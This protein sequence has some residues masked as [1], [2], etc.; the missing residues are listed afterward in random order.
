MTAGDIPSGLRLCRASGWN[1]LSRDWEHFLEVNPDGARVLE[2]QER[3][4]G[5]VATLRYGRLGWLAMVLVDPSQRRQGL[6]TQLLSAGLNLLVDVE[7]V[8][9]DATPAGEGMYRTR[10]F[11]E[12]ERLSRM[13][14]A[15][16]GDGLSPRS[17]I[18]RRMEPADLPRVAQWDAEAFGFDR[19]RLIEWLYASAPEYAWIAAPQSRGIN[20]YTLGRHGF[21]FE[22]LG[23]I[24]ALNRGVAVELASACLAMH[25]GRAFVI[26]ARRSEPKWIGWLETIGLREQ[27]PFLRMGRDTRTRGLPERRFASAGPEFG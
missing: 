23:P 11:I 16:L 26:D 13:T 12:L 22:H 18:V 14:G 5:T 27:R 24:V 25:A 15:I 8:A 1:Q 7:G 19:R 21:N 9:L 10:G 17:P 4:V 20:G 2:A 6:G 3:I